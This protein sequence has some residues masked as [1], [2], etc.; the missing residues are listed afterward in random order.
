MSR[1]S[2]GTAGR[3][4]ALLASLLLLGAP[5]T[6]TAADAADAAESLPLIDA[7]IHYSHDAWQGLPPAEA[8]RT[9]RAAGLRRAFVSSSSDDG[10]Q[11]LLREA[12]DLIVPVLRPYRT[13]GD[14]SGWFRDPTVVAHLE[15]RLANNRYAG[16]GEFHVYG[17][18]ARLPVMQR[19]IALARERRIF[20]H[21]HSD[22]AAVEAIFAQDPQAIVLWAHAGFAEPEVVRRLLAR[23]PTLRADLAFRT[24]HA[25]DGELDDAWRRL[26]T[27]FP[28][29]FMLGTD[30]FTPERWYFVAEHAR[31]SRRW[32]ATLPVELRE[33]IGWR[34]AQALADAVFRTAGG[35]T[36]CGQTQARVLAQMPAA[37]QAA[38]KAA[39]SATGD[40]TASAAGSAP[41][42]AA[43]SVPA[44]LRAQRT[45]IDGLELNLLVDPEAVRVGKPFS[46]LACVDAAASAPSSA[47][48]DATPRLRL[49]AQMPAHGHGMN[50]RPSVQVLADTGWTRFDGLLFHMPG[51][52][53]L[54]LDAIDGDQRR[55]MT[56]DLD[57]ER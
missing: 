24:D 14:V 44:G 18:D 36:S 11:M 6:A 51:R 21:A 31:T 15:S 1:R 5:A 35:A 42:S 45:R 28:D 13:R 41:G 27:A 37:A 19:V 25:P 50:Y 20:L 4:A 30:T 53:Q 17:E 47:S 2:C 22:A 12:P 43:G 32:L 52:W 34:N 10:T 38:G 29:R 57:V 40:A 9:L 23:Y 49:D 48:S 55:R 39:G 33:R 56:L 8:I 3:V 26:F 7:H 16:I 54:A 46:V